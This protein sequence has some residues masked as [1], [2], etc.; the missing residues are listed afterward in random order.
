L[1]SSHLLAVIRAALVSAALLWSGLIL[2][3][4]W[5][6]TSPDRIPSHLAAGTY[7]VGAAVCHQRPERSFHISSVRLPV[8]ARCTGLYLS[9]ALGAI[10]GLAWAGSREKHPRRNQRDWRSWLAAAAVPTA[11]TLVLEWLGLWAPSNAA[12]AL[13]AAPLGV[14]GGL[15]VAVGLSFRSKL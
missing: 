5:I 6:A 3:A 14:V 10:A 4:P 2:A 8:C 1:R 15:L 11:L 12:R 7:V 9:A 13:A